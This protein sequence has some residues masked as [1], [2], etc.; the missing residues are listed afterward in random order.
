VARHAAFHGIKCVVTWGGDKE[1]AWAEAITSQS[2]GA[3]VLAPAT[4]LLELAALLKRAT[5]FVGSDTGPL[6]LAA[7]V[8][9][10][11][12]ALFGAS[13]AAA[14]GP[15]GAGHIC[16]QEAMDTSPGR[17]RHEADNWA[18]R[19]ITVEAVVAACERLLA[20][21]KSRKVA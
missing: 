5:L 21:Y 10:P 2:D 4:S 19:R 12:V 11:C 8:G 18:M 15:Y 13:S 14:C 3:A 9:T 20:D 17:K 16:L 7:A 6:H 1:C